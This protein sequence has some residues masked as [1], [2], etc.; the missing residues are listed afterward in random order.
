MCHTTL[1]R[2]LFVLWLNASQ[3]LVD[4]C[5]CPHSTNNPNIVVQGKLCSCMKRVKPVFCILEQDLWSKGSINVQRVCFKFLSS[6]VFYMISVVATQ[7]RTGEKNI[8]LFIYLFINVLI[9]SFI[10]SFIYLQCYT[11][12]CTYKL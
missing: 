3:W 4:I 9:H 5:E 12:T 2:T 1:Y 7:V 6:S 8:Y 10:H 11:G